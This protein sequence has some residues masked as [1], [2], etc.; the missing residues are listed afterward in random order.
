[1][2]WESTFR[3]SVTLAPKRYTLNVKLNVHSNVRRRLD[4][5]SLN[6][7]AIEENLW[8]AES[9]ATRTVFHAYTFTH[10]RHP[11]VG[12]ELS[13]PKVFKKNN[14]V[15]IDRYVDNKHDADNFIGFE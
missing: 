3:L 5:W 12:Q 8:I 4:C 6:P 15:G 10:L 7:S 9:P 1:M 14:R 2:R 11:A 13:S